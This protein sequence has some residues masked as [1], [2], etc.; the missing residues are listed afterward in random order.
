MKRTVLIAIAITVV[1]AAAAPLLPAATIVSWETFGNSGNEP[2]V[3]PTNVETGLVGLNLERGPG[4]S[5]PS[6]TNSFNSSAWAWSGGVR[7]ADDYVSFGF[8]VQAPFKVDDLSLLFGSRSSNAGPGPLG[9]FW[10]GDN[11]TDPLHT[12]THV[13]ELW[14][15]EDID[16]AG[17]GTLEAGVYEFQIQS[18]ANQRA[19]D[20]QNTI[21]GGG[22]MRIGDYFQSGQGFSL[23]RFE[24]TVT[25]EPGRAMLLAI[26]GLL[27]LARRRRA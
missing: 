16:L 19:S 7:Q 8:E 17:L 3:A 21:A 10:S 4:L 20:P 25:P 12:W 9:L 22:T 14:S 23:F 15:N 1:A 13:N 6:G 2:F 24:G 27:F 5:A 26:G 11:F 18:I